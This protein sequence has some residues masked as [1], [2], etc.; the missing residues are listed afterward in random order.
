MSVVQP[1]DQVGKSS[2]SRTAW[3]RGAPGASVHP[4]Q[5]LLRGWS[6]DGDMRTSHLPTR[7]GAPLQP[8]AASS[9]SGWGVHNRHRQV[10]SHRKRLSKGPHSRELTKIGQTVS[11]VHREPSTGWACRQADSPCCRIREKKSSPA[12]PA[13]WGL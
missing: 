13:C 9:G 11:R 5:L 1:D 7:R 2:R 12:S 4:S 3:W 6:V 10:V 8:V